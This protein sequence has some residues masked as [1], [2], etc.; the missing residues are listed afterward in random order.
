MLLLVGSAN[1]DG[2][3][4]PDPDRYLLG[5]DTSRLVSFGVGRHFCLGASLAR[6]EARVCLEELACRGSPTTTSTPPA[7][8][9][10]TRS[11]CGASPPCPP[12]WRPAAWPAPPTPTA[13]PPWSP[14]RRAASAPPPP[15]AWPRPAIP[16]PW[17]PAGWS[18][19]T[20]LAGGALRRGRRG[21]GRPARPGRRG[22]HRRLRRR[23]HRGAR[24]HRGAGVGGR[25][26]PAH[27]GPRHAPRRLLPPA[28]SQPAGG[29][30]PGH[31]AGARHGGAAAWRRRAGHL[32]RGP[33]PPPHDV[34][35]RRLQVGTRGPGPGHAC[36]SSRA[37][38]S[39]APS[40]GPAP[41]SPRWAR[42]SRPSRCP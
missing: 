12:R 7:S 37:P 11:T 9:G 20:D 10:C 31:Q 16:W 2:D 36:W 19:S 24:R 25:R 18:A 34:Q 22:R 30:A 14:A 15:A 27:Q 4:F 40:C 1:R 29:P 33:A 17:P 8:I 38:A 42:G 26:R 39:A 35:L 23:G 13:V 41:P 6:L 5:R 21:R 32:R 3:V 28:G